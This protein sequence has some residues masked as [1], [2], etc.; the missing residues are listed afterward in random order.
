MKL[1]EKQIHCP[2]CH[3]DKY[4]CTKAIYDNLPDVALHVFS[5]GSFEFDYDD[6]CRPGCIFS[7][8]GVFDYC[9]KCKRPLGVE[10]S[11]EDN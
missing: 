6:D 3:E 7:E 4:G 2:Y 9:P 11:D 8:S 1:T 5:D 10:D